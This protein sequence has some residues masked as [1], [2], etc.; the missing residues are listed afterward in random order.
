MREFEWRTPKEEYQHYDRMEEW[1]RRMSF[2]TAVVVII[3]FL[4][5]GWD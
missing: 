5:G 1:T 2:W 4:I 3:L